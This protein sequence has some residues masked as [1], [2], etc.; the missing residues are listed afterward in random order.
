MEGET[1][2]NF[3]LKQEHSHYSPC[4]LAIIIVIIIMLL[5]AV[6]FS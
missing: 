3:Y 5:S 6:T 1:Y 4:Y 2:M